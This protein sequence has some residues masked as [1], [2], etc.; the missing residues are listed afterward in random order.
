MD[1]LSVEL[2]FDPATCDNETIRKIFSNRVARNLWIGIKR[3]HLTNGFFDEDCLRIAEWIKKEIPVTGDDLIRIF[4]HC[5]RDPFFRMREKSSRGFARDL[6]PYA[7]QERD[8]HYKV[9]VAK[10]AEVS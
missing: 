7:R 10:V 9:V 2:A 1:I 4:R 6:L 8:F 3:G 5:G